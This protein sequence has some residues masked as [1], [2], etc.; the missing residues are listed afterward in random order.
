MASDSLLG[1][2]LIQLVQLFAHF[3]DGVIMLLSQGRHGLLVLNISLFQVPSEFGH[4]SL[5]PLVEFDLSGSC[6]SSL[7]QSFTHLLDF[8]GK[9]R[10]LFLG[11]G[12]GLSLGL[13]LFLQFFNAGLEMARK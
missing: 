13:K 6:A 5:T 11:F 1:F 2:V 12:S 3:G 8:S 10:S 7:L 9:V 4:L